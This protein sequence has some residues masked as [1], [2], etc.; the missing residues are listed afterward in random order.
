VLKH[1]VAEEKENAFIAQ[2]RLELKE[3]RMARRPV[4]L[5]AAR[6]F[7]GGQSL[8]RDGTAITLA[9][10]S[11]EPDP[12]RRLYKVGAGT[13][14]RN[15]I[16]ALDPIGFSPAVM[17]SNNDFGVAS[18][19][20][21]NAHGWPA[22]FGPFGT[23]VRS[24]RIML[25]DGTILTCSR[26]E[27]PEL[28]ALTMGGYGLFGVILD[29]E[30]EMISNML[31]K[32]SFKVVLTEDFAQQF[33]RS[34][35]QEQGTR[36][37][38]GRVSV[39]RSN[40]LQEALVVVFHEQPQS[41][42]GLPQ[43]G[44]GGR[45]AGL[46]R[47]IYRA[48]TGWETGKRARWFAETGAGPAI[49][50]GRFTRNSLL[51]EPVSNLAGRFPNRTDILHEYF[52]PPE[53]LTDFVKACQEVISN[54]Q[55]ELLN[56]TLR[57]LDADKIS[58]LAYAPTTRIAAVMSFSQEM[59]PGAEADMM[60]MTEELIDRV[61]AIGGSFYLPYRLHARRDQVESS[62]PRT[63]EFISRKRHYDQGLLFRNLMW[64][65]YFA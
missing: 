62:Y 2:L 46:A 34:I 27:N 54:S 63:Q 58:V 7:M 6:H 52:I 8:A 30:V 32:P 40:F 20:S 35:H 55:Q 13:R 18:T 28:F 22:P 21:V 61:L 53:R 57:Y 37:A 51:N 26:E 3:A 44:S 16:A 49:A 1:W 10:S 31:L 39:A 38:Y 29:L 59:A 9:P 4:A 65:T 36:M 33:P 48:Q 5:G 15:V 23:T 25:A 12:A 14:W 64:D 56:I 43:A 60:R 50:S 17:Q 47:E 41:E 11:C 42:G 19:F 24:F 45:M